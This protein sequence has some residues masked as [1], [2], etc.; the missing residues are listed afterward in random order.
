MTS[1]PLSPTLEQLGAPPAQLAGHGRLN[2]RGIPYLYL[3]S[4]ELTAISEVRPWK[5]AELTLAEFRTI[6]TLKLANFSAQA[7]YV[8]APE[9]GTQSGLYFATMMAL[10]LAVLSPPQYSPTP[11]ANPADAKQVHPG[12]NGCAAQCAPATAPTCKKAE[13]LAGAQGRQTAL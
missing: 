7:R 8:Q 5:D 1:S 10:L 4:D 2:P 6:R 3:A 13:R 12:Q 11:K 9:T